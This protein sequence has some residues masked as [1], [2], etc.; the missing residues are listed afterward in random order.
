VT[1]IRLRE[2]AQNDNR[3]FRIRVSFDDDAEYQVTVTDPAD[4]PTE[5]NIA[6]YFEEHL[7]Y[8]DGPRDVGYRT[9]TRPLIDAVR[10][11]GLPV[12]VDQV[13]P[14]TCQRGFLYFET[15]QDNQ[16]EPIPAEALANLLA[17]HRVPVAILNACQ[18]ATQSISE[19]GLAQRL[20]EAGVPVALGMAY[21]VTVSAAVRAMPALYRRI[22]NGDDLAIAVTAARRELRDHRARRA[23]FGH[24]LELE[25]WLLPVMFGQRR[26]HIQLRDMTAEE[27]ERFHERQASVSDEPPTEYGFV[28]RDLDIQAIEHKLAGTRLDLTPFCN[29][30]T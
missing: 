18:S 3:E 20:A 1:V 23:Y 24:E 19:A 8:P 25:D 15:D 4:E 14:G 26:L 28:G 22:V 2:L 6:W 30:R 7:R 21:S 16:A 9:I 5:T 27:Y 17:E 13:R 11:A 29:F 10:T 12:T